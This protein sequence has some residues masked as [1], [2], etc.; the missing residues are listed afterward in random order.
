MIERLSKKFYELLIQQGIAE[1]SAI[2]LGLLGN[3]IILAFI[4][5]IFDRF[6]RGLVIRAF[7]IFS[8]KNKNKL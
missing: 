8:N 2:Y 7:Q 6:L 5:F 3:I 1:E 4:I